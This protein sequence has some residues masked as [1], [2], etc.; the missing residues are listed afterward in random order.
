MEKFNDF[1]DAPKQ[2]E[3]RVESPLVNVLDKLVEGDEKRIPI[4]NKNEISV[5]DIL[6]RLV[7]GTEKRQPE[8]IGEAHALTREERAEQIEKNRENGDKREAEVQKE[9]E[10]QYPADED[11]TIESEVYLRDKDGN[12]IRDPE[13]GE[14]RRIDFVVIKDGKV[15]DSVEVTSQTADKTQQSAKEQRIRDTGGN[16]IKDSNGNLVEIPNSVQTRIERRD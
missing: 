14:A 12:I 9:L 3:P 4:K 10:E 1:G 16:Y 15:V 13:T 5:E 11:Y 6:D 7:G 8:L 2:P